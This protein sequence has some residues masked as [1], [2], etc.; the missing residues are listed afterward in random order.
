MSPQ[1]SLFAGKPMFP[2][3]ISSGTRLSATFDLF[4]D[5][6]RGEGKSAHTIKAFRGDMNLLA[7]FLDDDRPIAQLGTA[8]LEAFLDWM[9]NERGVPCSRKTYARRVTTLK[10]Y[11]KWLHSNNALSQDPARALRQRSGPAPL[12]DV[13][14]EQ[15]VTDCTAASGAFTKSGQQ[16]YRPAF[17]FQLLLRTGIKKAETGRLTLGDLD[18]IVG[19][20][21]ILLVRHK[22]R[23]VYKERR[24]V[25]DA[26]IVAL[27]DA[28]REQYDVDETLFDCTTRNLEYILTDIGKRAKVPF[29]LSFEV[30]RWTMAVSAYRAGVEDEL[31]REKLG[32]SKTSWYETG[33]K[34]RRLAT[35][36]KD[37]EM[38]DNAH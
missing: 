1:L 17:L 33:N 10:V 7:G 6:L 15:Q 13:L 11:F 31:I 25:L 24:I 26:A 20:A 19:A 38:S 3:D 5:Y 4:V 27:L 32:L 37:G 8:D 34:I 35:N 16:D 30:M 14:N 2:E 28:Y 12:S 36:L 23:D 18:R 22:G 9:E 21:P 29:K